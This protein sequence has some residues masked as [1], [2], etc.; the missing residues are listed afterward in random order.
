M[1]NDIVQKKKI[2]LHIKILNKLKLFIETLLF[3]SLKMNF[4]K[5]M[6]FQ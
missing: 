6:V 5:L 2:M 1:I 3:I 4:F